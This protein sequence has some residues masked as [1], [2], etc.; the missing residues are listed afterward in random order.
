MTSAFCAYWAVVC[1]RRKR[2]SRQ[3]NRCTNQS[4]K[5]HAHE[6]RGHEQCELDT[7]WINDILGACPRQCHGIFAVLL[8]ALR[9]RSWLRNGN[10]GAIHGWISHLIGLCSP[11]EE[12]GHFRVKCGCGYADYR[13]TVADR[14]TEKVCD[15][16]AVAVPSDTSSRGCIRVRA[17]LRCGGKVQQVVRSLQYSKSQSRKIIYLCVAQRETPRTEDRGPGLVIYSTTPLELGGWNSDMSHHRSE[18]AQLADN[19]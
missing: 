12:G 15:Q 2:F 3:E 10:I 17:S 11:L 18:R 6:R 9:I 4:H 1:C 13:S 16:I 8:L 14:S 5:E 19:S 7:F